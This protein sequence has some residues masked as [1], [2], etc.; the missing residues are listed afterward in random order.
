MNKAAGLIFVATL[1]VSP[2]QSATSQVPLPPQCD[3]LSPMDFEAETEDTEAISCSSIEARQISVLLCAGAASQVQND[4]D[5]YCH[6]AGDSCLA[7]QVVGGMDP[8]CVESDGMA[9]ISCTF[10]GEYTC[11]LHE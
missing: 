4:C 3:S 10:S 6:E 1:S 7:N 5:D 2:Y 8:E 9:T 11:L